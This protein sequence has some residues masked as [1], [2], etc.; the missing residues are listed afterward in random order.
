MSNKNE[1]I[2]KRKAVRIA[3][4]KRNNNKITNITRQKLSNIH[5]KLN[6]IDGYPDKN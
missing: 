3:A 4:R 5:T 2:A 1:I 6:S